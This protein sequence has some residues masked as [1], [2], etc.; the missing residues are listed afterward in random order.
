MAERDD[1]CPDH[2][3]RQE[4]EEGHPDAGVRC[5]AERRRSESGCCAPPL[6]GQEVSRGALDL[7][8]QDLAP[9]VEL[10]SVAKSYGDHAALADFSLEVRRGEFLTLLGP[11][12]SGKTTVLRLV[13]GFEQ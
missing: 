11:S 5:Q 3:D 12:G 1:G 9:I 13:A 7:P 4:R 6:A 8:E 2:R 10:R